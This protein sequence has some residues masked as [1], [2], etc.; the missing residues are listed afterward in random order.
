MIALVWNCRGLGN[1]HA[2]RALNNILREQVLD[3]VFLSET[4]LLRGEMEALK[5]RLG[6]VNGFYVDCQNRGGG[7]A[8]LWR[9][10]VQL[11]IMRLQ[12]SY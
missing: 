6:F 2:I 10:D 4:K 1:P 5:R 9:D 7:L 12:R 8:L 11:S 3:F